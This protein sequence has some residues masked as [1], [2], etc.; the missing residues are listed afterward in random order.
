MGKMTAIGQCEAHHAVVGLKQ[1][2]EDREVG[3][4]ATVRLR[5]REEQEH[6]LGWDID[7]AQ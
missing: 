4:T 3:W 1:A 2:I 5:G 7:N 6:E